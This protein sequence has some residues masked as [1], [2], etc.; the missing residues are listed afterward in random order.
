MKRLVFLV[1]SAALFVSGVSVFSL[2]SPGH[3]RVSDNQTCIVSGSADSETQPVALV[4][5]LIYGRGFGTSGKIISNDQPTAPADS[6]TQSV[7]AIKVPIY[8][9][10]FGTS[11]KIQ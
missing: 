7:S 11:G 8:G 5:V 6:Q 4:K 10:G 1:V 3:G 9:R 2:N